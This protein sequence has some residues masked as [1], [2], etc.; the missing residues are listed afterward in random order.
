[1]DKF[2]AVSKKEAKNGILVHAQDPMSRILC[3]DTWE[4][5]E[6]EEGEDSEVY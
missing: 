1:M 3:R 4:G 2:L 6:G 5:A